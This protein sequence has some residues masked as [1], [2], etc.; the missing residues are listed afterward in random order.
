[1][2][3]RGIAANLRVKE[4]FTMA[5]DDLIEAIELISTFGELS[6]GSNHYGEDR[7]LPAEPIL[8]ICSNI[9]ISELGRDITTYVVTRW[10]PRQYSCRFS[11]SE[12]EG[13]Q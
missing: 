5:F 1:M 13:K 9:F 3:Y 2:L 4:S 8:P 6:V 11:A 10:I 12:M 7:L